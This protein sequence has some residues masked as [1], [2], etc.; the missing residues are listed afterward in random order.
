MKSKNLVILI[1]VFWVAGVVNANIADF[2][3]LSL[4]PESYWNGSD[5]TGDFTS[6]SAVFNNNF[7]NWGGGITSWD[8]WAYSNMS[9]TTTPGYTNQY[10]AIT[11]SA[12]SGSNYGV[13]Y[14][15]WTEPP[16]IIFNSAIAVGGIYVTNTTY[17]Y[18]AMKNGESPA[19][20][21]GDED[22]CK[23]SITGKDESGLSVGTIDFYLADDGYIVD[24][25]EY[26]GLSSLGT[27]KSLEFSLSSSDFDVVYGMNTPAYFAMDTVVPEPATMILF[28]LGGLL[29]RRG[30]K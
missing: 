26:V 28:S 1:I 11:G 6:G 25:W 14:I 27:V 21:F 4:G 9:D 5:E 18:L 16:S 17:A 2:D 7:T 15:G 20:K 13:A 22:W 10:S 24:A 12:Q 29:F 3:D 30:R 23:L 19:R 8:G